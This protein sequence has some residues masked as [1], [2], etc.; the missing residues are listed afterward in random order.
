MKI[1]RQF[2]CLDQRDLGRIDKNAIQ[3]SCFERRSRS[4][5]DAGLVIEPV[6]ADDA[7]KQVMA[8]EQLIDGQIKPRM[9][10][11]SF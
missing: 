4:L 8:G 3:R 7:C 5:N 2:A 11:D 6:M 10:F 9:T 1:E